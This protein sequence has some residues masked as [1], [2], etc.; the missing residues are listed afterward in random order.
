MGYK[1]SDEYLTNGNGVVSEN[2]ELIE[3]FNVWRQLIWFVEIYGTTF[4]NNKLWS[5]ISKVQINP[6]F[7]WLLLVICV[8]LIS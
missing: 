6:W 3:N 7:D 1:S 2:E 8:V 5:Y 4:M